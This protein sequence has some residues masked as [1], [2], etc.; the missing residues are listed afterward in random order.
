MPHGHS[1][2]NY[3]PGYDAVVAFLN[4]QFGE[5][6]IAHQEIGAGHV[7]GALFV[8]I[9][10]ITLGL[11]AHKGISKTSDA[12]IPEDTL[13]VR[14]F[15]ELFTNS[16]YEMLVDVLGAKKAKFFLPL[17]GTCAF[18]IFFSNFLGLVP[19]FTPPT[20]KL[21]TTAACAIVIFGATHI[22]GLKE[23][24]FN[25]ILHLFGPPELTHKWFT[26]I[27][28]L[29]Y[30][31][32]LIEVVSHIA[33]PISLSL[34]LMA[35]MFADHLVVGLFLSLIPFLIPIPLMALGLLVVTVQTLVFCLL[36]TVYIHLAVAHEE[37]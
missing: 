19:G 20:D 29:P 4:A 21:N 36:S 11:I 24:G 22:F 32:F 5:T 17:I 6:F 2:F 34:R 13:T 15:I 33:R 37:H 10:L 3:M 35:N 27:T 28:P 14:T 9:V 23:N 7:F 26:W 1:W 31:M 16:V 8:A 12:I 18:F 25:H 30:L